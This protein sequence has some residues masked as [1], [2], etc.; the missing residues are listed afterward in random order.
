MEEKKEMSFED[1]LARLQEI[2]RKVEGGTLS[3]DESMKLYEEGKKL[4]KELNE[5]LD[6]ATET[7]AEVQ[8]D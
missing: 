4:I 2:V 5:T 3:I 7:V 1:K 8:N 6:E